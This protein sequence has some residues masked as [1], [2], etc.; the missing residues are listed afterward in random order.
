MARS[1]GGWPG[2]DSLLD[3][4]VV[5]AGPGGSSSA[6]LLARAGFQ[7][8]AVDRA[9]FP[10]DKACSEYM[11]PETVRLLDRLGVVAALEAAGAAPL[12]GTQ[13]TAARGSRL[14]GR[15]ALADAPP[16]RPTGL[17]ISRR[18]LDE[19]LVRAAREAGAAVLERTA[20]ED[21]LYDRGAVA[22]AVVRDDRGQRQV[23][24]ARLTIGADG[25]RSLVARR[26]GPRRHG[27][28]RRMA[29]VAHV[30]GVTGMGGSAEM[31]V[32][33]RGYV[34]LNPIGEGRT[35]VALV[36]PASHGREARGRAEGF[37]LE[38]LRAFPGLDERILRG[39]IARRVLATGPFAAW[40]SRVTGDGVALVGD[41]ADFFDP[42]TG[43]GIYSALR[44][45]ALLAETAEIALTARGLVTAARLAS[46][47][48]A[49]RRAFAGKWAV[50]R[51]I[52]YGMLFP[53]LFDHA[54]ER[55]GRRAGMADTLIGVTA[56]FVPARRVLNPLFLARMLF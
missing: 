18:I 42:F 35:N 10:R 23:L 12:H 44:G 34:G 36:V 38:S 56:D 48:R 51:L 31:H 37:F 41:A 54:V 33:P 32:G 6:A 27:R 7:V 45:A 49:R 29:F 40:S 3:V 24:R 39:T 43:E 4:L 2:A 11:S 14:H 16:F 28:P 26:L 21:L 55:L 9:A 8:A 53:A 13:V 20:V 50:E 25:L 52:G 17:S 30:D 5:G 1:T 19:M 15:F 46:Y 47:R 22:G